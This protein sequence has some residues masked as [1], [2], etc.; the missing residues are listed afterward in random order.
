MK[1]I[2]SA[3]R[4]ERPRVAQ[5]IQ[6]LNN[7]SQPWFSAYTIIKGVE[8]FLRSP[9]RKVGQDIH[10]ELRCLCGARGWRLFPEWAK[11]IRCGTRA[12]EF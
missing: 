1:G 4:T 9:L 7:P 12:D 5:V 6:P 3:R 10:G 11:C 8:V 2:V